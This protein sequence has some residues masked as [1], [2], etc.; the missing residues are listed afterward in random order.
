[1][2]A[3]PVRVRSLG[4][5]VALSVLLVAV[6]ASE[7]RAAPDWSWPV[8]GMVITHYSNDAAN[9]YAGGVHRGIDIAAPVGAAVRA[10]RAGVVTYA[11]RL[12]YSGLTVAVRTVDGYVTSYLHLSAARVRR[13]E[14][15]GGRDRLGEVGTTGRRSKPEPHLHF[16]VRVA[17]EEHHYVD[18]LS[19]LPPLPAPSA[20]PSPLPA[21]APLRAVPEPVPVRATPAPRR[22]P[23]APR[24]APRGERAPV[25]LPL[26][27]PRHRSMP[28]LP[29]P[30]GH[31]A[32]PMAHRHRA[33]GAPVAPAPRRLHDR[34]AH[35]PEPAPAPRTPGRARD[36]G[37]PLALGGLGVLALAL[38]G[39]SAIRAV[40]RIS[41][42]ALEPRSGSQ[43]RSR[44]ERCVRSIRQ[45]A[46][47]ALARG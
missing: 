8:E 33:H 10:A 47:A 9:P 36:W 25:H 15:I 7:A 1:M 14:S 28:A 37:R 20:A 41:W 40:R 26:P 17:G 38:F 35:P 42:P 2:R 22:A 27:A 18:P 21:P 12:G 13:G 39:K 24:P 4:A 23:S 6:N 3:L 30:G 44:W 16:G 19:L 43:L 34:T 11:G 32:A 29:F 45:A 31:V 5:A 46:K